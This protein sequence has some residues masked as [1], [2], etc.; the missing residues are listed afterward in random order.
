METRAITFEELFGL[1][2]FK[3]ER[4]KISFRIE[5]YIACSHTDMPCHI[6]E[7]DNCPV[8][9]KLKVIK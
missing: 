4:N 7:P 5:R 1:C 6:D 3:R 2:R 9:R 8:W